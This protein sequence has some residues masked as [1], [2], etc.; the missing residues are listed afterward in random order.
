LRY[1]ARVREESVRERDKH[2]AVEQA[3]RQEFKETQTLGGRGGT[4]TEGQASRRVNEQTKISK[5][6]KNKSKEE[7]VVAREG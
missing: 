3:S 5:C 6:G 4:Y 1:P 2:Q 7:Q